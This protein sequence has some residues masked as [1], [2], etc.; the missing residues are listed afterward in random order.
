MLEVLSL[1]YTGNG[2]NIGYLSY[3]EVLHK[4]YVTS[5]TNLKKIE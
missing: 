1:H 5:E 2:G 4:D 3:L